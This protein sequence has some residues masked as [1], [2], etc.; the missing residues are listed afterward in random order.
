MGWE[1]VCL[2]GGKET[3]AIIQ[4]GG[5]KGHWQLSQGKEGTGELWRERRGRSEVV[6][7]F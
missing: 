7:M 6:D 5:D 3:V 2:R 1:P 4:D